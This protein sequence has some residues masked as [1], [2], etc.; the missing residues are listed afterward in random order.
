MNTYILSLV[1]QFAMWDYFSMLLQ[2]SLNI[3]FFNSPCIMSLFYKK[4]WLENKTDL[5]ILG[6]TNK[7]L[8]DCS[9]LFI[10]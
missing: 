10:Y 7:Y 2:C 3:F 1:L 4:G 8:C 9:L 6:S 5:R